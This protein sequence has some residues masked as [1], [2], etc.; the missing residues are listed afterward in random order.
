MLSSGSTHT[1]NLLFPYPK[2]LPKYLGSHLPSSP[3][4]VVG[5]PHL[6]SW[7]KVPDQSS[8]V[9]KLPSNLVVEKLRFSYQN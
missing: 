2:Y 5:Q 4:L 6:Q 3:D 7:P 1:T 8:P 9:A